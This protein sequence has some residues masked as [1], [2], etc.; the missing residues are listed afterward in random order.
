LWAGKKGGDEGLNRKG[1]KKEVSWVGLEREGGG[2][3][4]TR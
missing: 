4:F 1:G 3:P 2:R